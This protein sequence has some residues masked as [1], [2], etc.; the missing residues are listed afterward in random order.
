[1][2][3]A[4]DEAN[5]SPPL[6]NTCYPEFVKQVRASKCDAMRQQRIETA[7]PRVKGRAK[8][9][10]FQDGMKRRCGKAKSLHLSMRLCVMKQDCRR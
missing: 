9:R 5:V 4:A 2:K 10:Q 7:D 8:N 3:A 1:M 6:V